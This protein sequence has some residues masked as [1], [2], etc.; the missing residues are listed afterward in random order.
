MKLRSFTI[1]SP[2]AWAGS[3]RL[4]P[5][6]L[7]GIC[8]FAPSLAELSNAAICCEPACAIR[9]GKLI[10][11]TK[12]GSESSTTTCCR[13]VTLVEDGLPSTSRESLR[14]RFTA[15]PL[16]SATV[17]NKGKIA[18]LGERLINSGRGR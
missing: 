4:K 11:A 6:V 15:G 3:A 17:S 7:K 2:I 9:L 14:V 8:H 10:C 13:V 18:E 12:N 16:F 1:S 5:V